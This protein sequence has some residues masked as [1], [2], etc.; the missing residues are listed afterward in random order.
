MKL[1]KPVCKYGY[2]M[3][4]LVDIFGARV[5]DFRR[6]MNGQTFTDCT[7]WEY[8]RKRGFNVG[9]GCGPHGFVYYPWDV[10]RYNRGLPVID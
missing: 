2:T 8:D 1:P 4:E 6:W 3:E 10:D 7:G 9:S 5:V